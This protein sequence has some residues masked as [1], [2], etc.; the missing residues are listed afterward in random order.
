ME[1]VDDLQ[2]N[3]LVLHQDTEYA[4]FNADALQLA[5]FLRLTKRDNAVELGSGTGV[6]CVLGTDVT[7][8]SFT[9]VEIQPR[10]VAL[11]KKSAEANRQTIRFLCADVRSAPE[12]LGRGAFTAAIMNPP[13]F[14]KGDRNENASYACSRHEADSALTAFLAAAFQLLNNGGKLFMIYPACALSDLFAALREHRMEPKRIR[15]VYS[16]PGGE[17]IRVL[18]EAKKLGK[19]GL[20]VEPQTWMQPNDMSE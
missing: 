12:L 17:A 10:L 11:S 2:H 20:I 3:G 7:G 16:K 13:Y 15:F 4:C 1:R 9:G 18:V 14:S 8:A 6:I 19:S 5:G